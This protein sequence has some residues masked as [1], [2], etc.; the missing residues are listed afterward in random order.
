MTTS[1]EKLAKLKAAKAKLKQ[2]QK[3]KSAQTTAT[4]T[5]PKSNHDSTNNINSISV[6]EEVINKPDEILKTEVVRER[7]ATEPAVIQAVDDTVQNKVNGEMAPSLHSLPQSIQAATETQIVQSQDQTHKL[8]QQINDLQNAYNNEST[9]LKT[10]QAYLQEFQN[11]LRLQQQSI[12]DLLTEKTELTSQVSKLN[13][14]LDSQKSTINSSANSTNNLS[15]KYD[16]I[17]RELNLMKESKEKFEKASEQLENELDT[18]NENYRQILARNE[19]LYERNSEL[20]HQV[21]VKNGDIAILKKELGSLETEKQKVQKSL[22]NLQTLQSQKDISNDKKRASQD[23]L[24]Q[25]KIEKL[26]LE[27]RQYQAQISELG[28]SVELYK[29]TVTGLTQERNKLLSQIEKVNLAW[30]NRME[31]KE[32]EFDKKLKER[33]EN[34]ENSSQDLA[35]NLSEKTE[36]LSKITSENN[37]L[38]QELEKLKIEKQRLESRLEAQILDNENLVN[39]SMEASE[40]LLAFQTKSADLEIQLKDR[41]S[42]LAQADS[43]RNTLNRAMTQNKDLKNNLEQITTALINANN[44][45]AQL[46]MESDSLAHRLKAYESGQVKPEVSQ[47]DKSAQ[48]SPFVSPRSSTTQIQNSPI[49]KV[50]NSTNISQEESIPESQQSRDFIE[51][52][53]LVQVLADEKLHSNQLQEQV[54]NLTSQLRIYAAKVKE[55]EGQ[56]EIL[57]GETD[58]QK[59]QGQSLYQENEV[60]QELVSQLVVLGFDPCCFLGFCFH[61]LSQNIKKS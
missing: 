28:K 56:G 26:S 41:Q 6:Q 46:Q 21:T 44:D 43:D 51:K 20:S 45:K 23:T 30:Q 42:L 58:V 25:V 47:I 55:L 40:Q 24:A 59:N 38:I 16:Q 50:N 48:N 11:R 34:T 57:K 7:A 36:N 17:R 15:F 27:S 39:S 49:S 31:I 61:D 37:N 9:Q 2:H 3:K 1:A 8:Q 22:T 18:L 19:E 53:Q 14:E 60:G 35:K 4:T 54:D 32:K 29:K 13:S 33:A 52:N 5:T 12:Q 10:A